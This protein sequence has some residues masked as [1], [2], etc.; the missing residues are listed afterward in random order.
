MKI[1]KLFK[2][3]L[4][5]STLFALF[6][7]ASVVLAAPPTTRYAPGETL[8]PT[9]APTDANCGV[10]QIYVN[11]TTLQYG[12]GTSTPYSKLTLWGTG[13]TTGKTFEVANFA[14]TTLFSLLD[15]GLAY[16]LG[17]LGVGTAAPT[18]KLEINGVARGTGTEL[19]TQGAFTGSVDPAWTLGNNVV[20]GTNNVVSTYAA[21]DPSLSTTFATTIGDTY[22]ITF[23][24]SGANAPMQVFFGTNTT[25]TV[26]VGP[27]SNGTHTVIL[28][29]NIGGPETITFDDLNYVV[30]D[31]WTLDDVSIQQT[32]SP[33]PA[34]KVVGFNGSTVLSIGQDLLANT[35]FGESALS[36]N[37]TGSGN[38]ANGYHSLMANTTG[39]QNAAF[40]YISL[41]SNTSGAQNTA[42]GYQSLS[43][44]ISGGQNTANGASALSS[45]TVGNGNTAMGMG[46]L[47][48]NTTGNNNTAIGQSAL[49]SNITGTDNVAGGVYALTNN[50]TGSFN[51]VVGRGALYWNASATSTTALGYFA[52]F[53]PAGSV[54]YNN[55]G[56]TYIGYQ[57][58][59]SADNNSDYNTFLGYRSGYN[60][61]TGSNN[62]WLGSATSSTAIAN[63]TTGSQNILIGNNISLPSATAS[64]QLNIGN[65]I[66]GTGI[67]GTGS[68]LS[69]GN[70]GIGTTTPGSLLSL[71]NT[72]GI[73]F[74]LATSTFSTTGGIN[75]ASGC[76]SV[77]GTCVGAGAGTV[78]SGTIGQFPYYAAAGT[79]LSATST[80]FITAAGNVGVGTAAPGTNTLFINGTLGVNS[81]IQSHK[82]IVAPLALI[83]TGTGALASTTIAVASGSLPQG[84][85]VD[86][87]G[88]FV[89]VPNQSSSNVS[90]YSINQST[91]ALTSIAAAVAAGTTP[92]IA[93]V[94]PTGRFV[95][96]INAFGNSVSMYSINQSTGALTSIAAA[97]AT[98]S[99]PYSVAVDPT[100][101]FVYVANNGASTVSMYSINQS[102]GALTSITTAIASG[103]SPRGVAVDPT[104]RFVYVANN[105]AS[106]VSMYSINQSTGALTSITTAIASGT[107]PQIIAADPTGR[108]VYVANNGASTVSMYSIDQNTGVLT[109][110]TTAIASGTA[111]QGLAVDPTGRFVF[112]ANATS[113]T[114]SMYS[115]NQST[116]ALTSIA[117][118]IATGSSPRGVGVDPTGR[119]AYVANGFGNTIS[120]Y[121][122][123]DFSAGFGVFS[124]IGIGTTTPANTFVVTGSP[125]SGTHTARIEN[126]LGGTTKNN[127]LLVVAG[128]NTGVAASEL[129]TFQRTDATVIGSISQNA[130]TTVAY[131]L[132]SD[133]RIKDNIASTT[134]GL[135][136][137]LKINVDDFSFISDPNKKRMTGFIAQE[138]NAIFPG[139]VTTNGDNG[140]DALAA[141]ST[142]WMVDYSKLTPLLVKGEQ[143][144]NAK[145]DSLAG[146]VAPVVGSPAESFAPAFFKNIFVKVGT[147]LADA[148]NN[149][150]DIFAGT[151][152]AKD[153]LCI[154]NTCVTE[155]QLKAL[156]KSSGIIPSASTLVSTTTTS[157]ITAA[158]ITIS[159]HGNN[160]ATIN[161][162][163]TYGDLGATITAP[164]SALNLGIKVSI[165]GGSLIDMSNISI[166]TTGAGVHH[167]VYTV[168][169]QSNATTT[170]E[171]ILNVISLAPPAPVATSTPTVATTTTASPL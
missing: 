104:G 31:T 63:L 111:P 128:N 170:A 49:G 115:I 60:T 89:Y 5:A 39:L 132:S 75:L 11:P 35:S 13:T 148:R 114:V 138:L 9:C 94:D 4:L 33:S 26:G 65:I 1:F 3:F 76:F 100:G 117:A 68:T 69:A 156:L 142:P 20:Y 29:A 147:W 167:I 155:D 108:F 25:P 93:A 36:A 122:I 97:V 19:V 136:D 64:G 151:F 57:S 66:Y 47:S 103:S 121:S 48:A 140:T 164:T 119:F 162:G 126:L 51:T 90:M 123:N 77:G 106:T 82:P 55:Q 130:A 24:I 67:T 42:L 109:A 74:S 107:G 149:I 14:S 154:N 144:L 71:G 141:T 78:G 139:A 41:S 171:R 40:G 52:A 44:N 101:R 61:T 38:T 125:A 80:L 118:D 165:D 113:N 84:V 34:F 98:G 85:A 73:N 163:D 37:T 50:S 152:H 88:R 135:A 110:I 59:Y 58:G 15:S 83:G 28:S 116:G 129:V 92:Y 102:T 45:N 134:F 16:F 7:F 169:D 21:G 70:I 79:A 146:L 6:L 72:G 22:V 23:T 145:L 30:G 124:G 17:N 160:P 150:T 168:V 56:G 137:V 10:D 105:G 54:T 53:G 120:M 166:D 12:I 86:P 8:N 133:R 95:Y 43:S 161:V 112:V 159:I 2:D 143:D 32:T 91:G 153:K 127:G 46:V 81:F 131:N 99:T 18:A 62:I 87:T 96:V 158:P 157:V 27:L